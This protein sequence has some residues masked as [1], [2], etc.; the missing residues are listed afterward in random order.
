MTQVLLAVAL[1]LLAFALAQR[2]SASAGHH[3]FANPILLATALIGAALW[4]GAMPL[5]HYSEA[6]QG[7]KLLLS[8]AIV[9]MAVPIWRQRGRLRAEAGP[10]LLAIGIGAVVGALSAV[11]GAALLGLGSS[12]GLPLAAKSVTSPFAIALMQELG[13][14]PALAAVLVIITGM[15]GAVLLPFAFAWTGLHDPAAR[16][17]GYGV[18]AHIVGTQRASS[19]DEAT[20]PLAALAMALT[21]VV[22]ALGLPLLWPLLIG[23]FD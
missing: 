3:P 8:W 2:L 4:A 23:W 9:A 6:T 7:F 11:G 21:G 17:L 14:A 22:T 1:T 16:A 19:E 18:A 10:L 5:A 20:G 13:G 15:I 12:L